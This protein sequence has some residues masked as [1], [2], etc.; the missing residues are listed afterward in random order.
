MAAASSHMTVAHRDLLAR[1]VRCNSMRIRRPAV[2]SLLSRIAVTLS[3]LLL[4]LPLGFAEDCKCTNME[5]S[6]SP[7][8][9]NDVCTVTTTSSSCALK[10]NVS[11]QAS[12]GGSSSGSASGGG[13]GSS[14]GTTNDAGFR[15]AFLS[16]IGRFQTSAS[17]LL[18]PEW[19]R[20]SR[21][22]NDKWINF[23]RFGNYRDNPVAAAAGFI[24][25]VAAALTVQGQ[26]AAAQSMTAAL[27]QSS[28]LAEIG[29]ELARDAESSTRTVSRGGTEVLVGT[30]CLRH[31]PRGEVFARFL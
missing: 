25:L 26:D 10:W 13:G 23:L 20:F 24:A 28:T 9:S 17:L 29:G 19:E 14:G 16:S 6:S 2:G 30:G 11:S 8:N 1:E 4:F 7:A 3:P 22:P 5:A 27:S 12:S 18:S 15:S 21:D 31:R